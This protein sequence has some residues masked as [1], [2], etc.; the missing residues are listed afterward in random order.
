MDTILVTGANGQLGS[1]L[2]ELFSA[3][4]IH[5]VIFTD[6]AELDI[7]NREA[8]FTFLKS[9]NISIIINCAAY[10]AVDKAEDEPVICQAVNSLAPGIL[11]DAASSL[12]I[13]LIHISTDYV[14][15]G[16]GP[17]PYKEDHP[18][19]PTGVYG[20]TKLSGEQAIAKSDAKYVIIRTS[21]LYSVYGNNFAKTILRLSQERESLNV[22]FDQV[23]TPTYAADLAGVIFNIVYK[24]DD[25]LKAGSAPRFPSGVY[26]Y[27]NE[28]VCS[29]FDFATEIV[30]LAGSDCIVHPV[31][32]DLFPSK[33][34]RPSYSV[35]DKTRIKELTALKIPYWRDSL[36]LFF[37][38]LQNSKK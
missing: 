2:K 20:K 30:K 1:E 19:A 18:A 7:T 17:V 21:W 6:Q 38:K 31:T 22:V 35:L 33:A 15:D 3:K 16:K 24:V 28:G 37:N 10:T 32:S 25:D 27:S 8:V 34:K 11:A 9:N 23:G 26:H 4:S 13:F 36:N 12:G 14:F 29:W 5:N